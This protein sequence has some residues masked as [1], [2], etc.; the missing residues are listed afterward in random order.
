MSDAAPARLY[1]VTPERFDPQDFATRLA[2]VLS[3]VPVACLRLSLG[4]SADE[5]D[6]RQAANHLLPVC[7][8]ADIALV[9]ADHYRLVR[10]LGLDGVHLEHGA[11]PVRSVRKDLGSNAIVGAAGGTTRHKAMAL[12][13]AGADYVTLGPVAEEGALG[14][15][16]L[17]PADLFAWWAEMIETPAVAEG[18]VGLDQVKLLSETA[19]FFVPDRRIWDDPDE[20]L[21][22]LGAMAAILAEA[23]G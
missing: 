8:D 13:E 17:A 21:E 9:I 19:D 2:A 5:D 14:A 10:P 6:W 1:L 23:D 11:A 4:A 15:G 18:G 7:H 16:E 3:K 12:A 22:V 20:T